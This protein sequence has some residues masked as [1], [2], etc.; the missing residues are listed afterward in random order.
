MPKHDAT[1][2]KL[3]K[4][5]EGLVGS[6]NIEIEVRQ[7]NK[8]ARGRSVRARKSS[9]DLLGH[10]LISRGGIEWRPRAGKY[11]RRKT[12]EQFAEMMENG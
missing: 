1:T 11:H 3:P 6:A 12:W 9:S 10:L 2:W 5:Y 8:P 4:G 7:S